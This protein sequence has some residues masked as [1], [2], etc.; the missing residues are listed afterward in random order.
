MSVRF[1]QLALALTA[2]MVWSPAPLLSASSSRLTGTLGG[3]VTDAVGV[4]QMGATVTVYNRL[5]RLVQRGLTDAKGLFS[6]DSLPSDV[7]SVRVQLASFVPAS[8]QNIS[9]NPGTQS[10][11]A[12]SLTNLFSS[13]D[14]VYQA[15]SGSALV[16]DE[17]KWVLRSS[18]A[19]KPVLRF[20]PSSDTAHYRSAIFSDNQALV[21]I[22]AGD[23]APASIGGSQPDLGTAFAFSTSIFGSN[24]LQLSGN[25][26]Y[27]PR[28]GAP[29]SAFRTSLARTD[30]GSNGPEL[31]V[32]VRQI[33]L[34]GRGG[35]GLLSGTPD[36]GPA[37]RTMTLGTIDRLNVT[38]DLRIEYG[39]TYDNVTFI[40]HL[41]YFSPFGRATYR[42]GS[43][44][45]LQAA[46]SSGAPPVDLLYSGADGQ[47]EIQSDVAAL[48]LFPRVS[49]ADNR[50]RVQRNTN[51]EVSYKRVWGSRT[52]S[53]GVHHE[54]TSNAA[55][56]IAAPSDFDAPGNL[57]PDLASDTSIFNIGS[58][59]SVGYM[60]SVEQT[61]GDHLTLTVAFGDGGSLR[62][63]D[64][65]LD[66]Q[67]AEDLRS[68]IHSQRRSWVTGQLAG[69]IPGIG[70]QFVTSY[71][72][73]DY[74]TLT[75]AHLYLTQ[76]L[77]S[78]AGLNVRIRQPIPRIG[79][80]PGRW[81]ATAELRNMLAQGYLPIS[82]EDGRR[83]L[84]IQSPRAVRGG[85]SLTF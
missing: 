37:L 75:P 65:A 52:F 31:N 72:W 40:D 77:R 19:T 15:P 82:M 7:Y 18:L 41:N 42:M 36:G 68:R 24:R 34:P 49:L 29:T 5:D 57:L 2:S 10:F 67:S 35:A 43:A 69:S 44:G 55:L 80:L 3:V 62:T 23:A 32:T 48:G 30:L 26:G 81:E 33:M 83:L 51:Y 16:S 11:L 27:S 84:L 53:V 46:Y 58:Y 4:A 61:V 78:E 45:S 25:V 56:T 38:E 79:I 59:R 47:K 13:I 70:T 8:K 60:A 14:L 74:R 9:I 6:F 39:I 1:L 85:F 20:L 63:D 21:R 73:T 50:T 54:R 17:W 66:T 12:I 22:S 76:P 64:R 28:L 71:Q